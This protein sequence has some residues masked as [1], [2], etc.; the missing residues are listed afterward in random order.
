MLHEH[1]EKNMTALLTDTRLLRG[2]RL[3]VDALAGRC[4]GA[5][6]K[7]IAAIAQ[8]MLNEL[9]LHQDAD[10]HSGYLQRGV[11][12]L[13]QIPARTIE[14]FDAGER[15]D[16]A[17]MR[18]EVATQSAQ[19]AGY[20]VISVRIDQLRG[21]FCRLLT[22]MGGVPDQFGEW[23]S[24]AL[25]WETEWYRRMG[26][27]E[28]PLHSEVADT[29]QTLTR[30]CLDAYLCNRFSQRSDLRLVDYRP[31]TVGL[32]KLTVMFET[33]DSVVG[34]QQLVLRGE[35]PDR[36]AKFDFGEVREEFELVKFAFDAGLPVAEP[37][38]V[39]LDPK[40][41]GRRF[42][43]GR[44]VEGINYGHATGVSQMPAAV[45]RALITTLAKINTLPLD[46]HTARLAQM[47]LK[48][49]LGCR[50]LAENT[51][52]YMQY[53]QQL[54]QMHPLVNSPAMSTA[55]TWLV[56]NVPQ[57]E[58]T[59][60]LLHCDYGPHNILVEGD[61]VSAV[62]DW[63]SARIGD[64]TEDLVYFIQTSRGQV[65]REQ[66]I[67][68][69]E[70]AGGPHIGEFRMRYF[71]VFHVVKVLTACFASNAL[72]AAHDTA[73]N[74]WIP[75]MLKLAYQPLEALKASLEAAEAAKGAVQ[76]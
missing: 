32:Q 60:G 23:G 43:V 54:L 31:L 28:V 76:G 1:A 27:A 11:A 47:P 24:R 63:E 56:N 71:E 68:W 52:L 22:R 12:I 59:P 64:P 20:A 51:R 57:D 25:A 55:L 30:E 41:L 16:I 3:A 42:M 26:L 4:E 44:R 40:A 6:S 37:L 17:R 38:W 72:Y 69:Y 33:E 8:M 49:W 2:L 5:E 62:L 66:M 53:W 46:K 7:Q 75:L 34:S 48:R 45:S 18:S 29:Q 39:E 73:R 36:F 65:D 50:S 15:D 21:L 19:G 70:E 67:N 58:G 9:A 35:Q 14:R 10:F 61:Q 13:E 74:D